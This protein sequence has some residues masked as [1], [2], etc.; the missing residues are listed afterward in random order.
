MRLV[1]GDDAYHVDAQSPIGGYGAD[2]FGRCSPRGRLLSRYSVWIGRYDGDAR[3]HLRIAG[4]NGSQ[5]ASASADG[6]LAAVAGYRQRLVGTA[7]VA[8]LHYDLSAAH[9]R[10]ALFSLWSVGAGIT[11]WARNSAQAGGALG[12]LY[13]GGTLGA[14]F[15]LY[16][17]RSLRPGVAFWPSIAYRALQPRGALQSLR[18]TGV[19]FGALRAFSPRLSLL[20]AVSLVPLLALVSPGALVDLESPALPG[21]PE[22][23][24]TPAIL[25][26]PPAPGVPAN[27]Q[28]LAIRL[29]LRG[30]FRP[31]LPEVQAG[32]QVPALPE[33]RNLLYRLSPQVRQTTQSK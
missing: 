19:S 2:L 12:T 1:C 6:N 3:W 22:V 9:A 10:V 24:L 27:L 18:A 16:S 31:R 33:L 26:G 8:G 20:S 7:G 11:P 23:P 29:A 25:W 30:L 32:L 17:L 15:T 21:L 13:A 28:V 14:S 5:N 4:T